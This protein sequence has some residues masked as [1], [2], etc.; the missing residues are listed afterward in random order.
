MCILCDSL[1]IAYKKVCPYEMR[2]EKWK[3]VVLCSKH[4]IHLCTEIHGP[5]SELEPKL[6]KVDGTSVMDYSWTCNS[7]SSCWNKFHD[8]YEPHGLI[9]MCKIDVTG[10]K[11]KF[12][13]YANTSDL[14][15]K[16]VFST[17]HRYG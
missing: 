5:R 17:R 14:Y 9:I 13:A 16:K 1:P 7:T 4:G 8:F 2:R 12:G 6:T 10:D 11:L 15:Q 3:G